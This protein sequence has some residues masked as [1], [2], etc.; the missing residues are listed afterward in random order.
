[1]LC[2]RAQHELPPPLVLGF[3]GMHFAIL[4]EAALFHFPNITWVPYLLAGRRNRYPNAECENAS[5]G[6][7]RT[8]DQCNLWTIASAR[9]ETGRNLDKRKKDNSEIR[10]VKRIF[11][12]RRQSRPLLTASCRMP[13][14]RK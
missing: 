2:P 13:V 6:F 11:G 3:F 5:S 9:L 1:M 4:G 14:C 12:Q 8:F 10:V 7:G